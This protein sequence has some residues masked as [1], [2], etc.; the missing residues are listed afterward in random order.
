MD[1][2]KTLYHAHIATL[3]QR[4]QQVLA[5]NKLDAMLIHSGEL[6]TVFLDDHTY[7]FKV[8]PQF[9]AWV[10]VTQVPNCWLWIDGVNKPKLW[11]YS[12]VDYWHNVEPLP[13]SFWTEDVEV[14]GLKSADEIAQLLPAQRDNVAYIG[15]VNARATQL[16]IASGNINPK[17]VIDFL[18][19]H[20]S[21]KTD[22][23][24]ACLR[25]AQKL[26]VAGHRAAKEAFSAG[27]SEFDINQ[28][29][30][31]ATGHR[32]TDVPY[33]NIIA[34][35][36]HAAVLHYTRLDHQPPAKRHSFLIDAGAEYLGYAADLTR[37]YA[38]QSS[39]LY[40]RMVEAMNAEELAPRCAFW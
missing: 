26:A 23:E 6:L 20:R 2:L 40:A 19:F 29:Y 7:P 35:N 27:L 22:Y 39:S 16:G 9:K 38:A 21:I 34:L 17:A 10:P 36:E 28:A 25:Q 31:T 13:D 24:L 3:Q 4:A 18:H 32:D 33:G 12:P 8:N 15:P 5:R 14:I 30:L 11:F 37:S 1:S